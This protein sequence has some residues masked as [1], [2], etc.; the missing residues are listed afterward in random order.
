M[1][2][3]VPV[4]PAEGTVYDNISDFMRHHAQQ[5]EKI[6]RVTLGIAPNEP[7]PPKA[8]N[9]PF[10]R[11]VYKPEYFASKDHTLQRPHYLEVDSEQEL[12]EAKEDGF[13]PSLAEAKQ[14]WE[15][16]QKKQDKRK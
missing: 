3:S 2:R 5:T 11:M 12:T 16:Q 14:A 4:Y 9:V 7:L 8:E 15:D 1:A 10:P 13:L 6:Q